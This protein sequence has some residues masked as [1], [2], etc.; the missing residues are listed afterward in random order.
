MERCVSVRPSGGKRDV[1][2]L[3]LPWH[4][5]RAATS[6]VRIMFGRIALGT[7]GRAKPVGTVNIRPASLHFGRPLRWPFRID[8]WVFRIKFFV[9]PVGRPFVEIAS[10]IMDAV[11][12][13]P[14]ITIADC[15]DS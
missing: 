13:L 1:P 6:Y 14:L 7:E 11:G 15:R 4:V 2:Q 10:Q 3:R 5:L 12:T 8:R 9:I